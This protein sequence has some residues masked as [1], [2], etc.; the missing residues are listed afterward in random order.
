MPPRPL[1][2][3]LAV[4]RSF[5]PGVRKAHLRALTPYASGTLGVAKD[6][7]IGQ[8]L[9][10]GRISCLCRIDDR[11]DGINRQIDSSVWEFYE[12]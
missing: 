11:L 10:E 4:R 8:G 2:T 7:A 1:S 9:T 3:I 5:V 12:G 6:L